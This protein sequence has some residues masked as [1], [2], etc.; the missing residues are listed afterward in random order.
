MAKEHLQG[1]KNIILDMGGVII[2]IDYTL[3]AKAFIQLGIVDFEKIF[4]QAKQMGFVDEFEKGNLSPE[5]FRNQLRKMSGKKFTDT[6]IDACWNA[7]ILDF[8]QNNLAIIQQL[9]QHYNL[10]LLSNNNAIHYK[11]LITKIEAIIP[12]QEFSKLFIKNYY[13]HL[14]NMRKPDKETFEFVLTENNLKAEETLFVDD[15]VQHINSA[16]QL[17]IKTL[18]INASTTLANSF[19]IQ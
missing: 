9:A 3:T 5:G 18:E 16:A 19:K 8:E 1:I 7:L 15:S 2:A 11:K 6:E 10:Y 12:F 4:T 14:L 17:N 13:S